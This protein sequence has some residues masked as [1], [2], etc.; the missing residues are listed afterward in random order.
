MTNVEITII[1]ILDIHAVRQHISTTTTT[2]TKPMNIYQ[3]YWD[4]YDYG[5]TITTTAHHRTVHDGGG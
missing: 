1:P 3:I 2:T 4:Y 5:V